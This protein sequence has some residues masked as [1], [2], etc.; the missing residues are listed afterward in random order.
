[1]KELKADIHIHTREDPE[2]LIL[3]SAIDLIDMAHE[4]GYKVL[5]ITNH[6]KM[7]YSHYLRDY[8]R[9]RGIVLIPG[10]EATIE[11]RHVLLYNVDPNKVK[12]DSIASL[13]EL[14]DKNTLIVAPHPFFPGF[15]ALR[16]RFLRHIELFDAVEISH[17]YSPMVDFN[18][19][20]ARI[21]MRLDIP[22]V[23]TSDAHQR[24][25]FGL[26]YTMIKSEQD[27]DAVIEA[28]K[29]GRARVVS[30][31]ITLPMM[32]GIGL[33]M[34]WRNQVVRRFAYERHAKRIAAHEA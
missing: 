32:A 26:T 18:R 7:T 10:M 23:G 2:D 19:F 28:I 12:R 9:E 31:P 22:L 20:A 5:A 8:A 3:Y 1:M 4:K 15:C 25:Q 14:R 33:K 11:G 29:A 21:A 27:P 13:R 6:N 34:F 16:G 17:F 24:R 30:R